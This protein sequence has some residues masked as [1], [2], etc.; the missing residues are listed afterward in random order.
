MPFQKRNEWQYPPTVNLMDLSN[1]LNVISRIENRVYH[2]INDNHH[3]SHCTFYRINPLNHHPPYKGYKSI[4]IFAK[5]RQR[6]LEEEVFTL[7]YM[8]NMESLR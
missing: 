7:T 1:Y 8:P 6:P 2:M 3:N 4:M 5:V